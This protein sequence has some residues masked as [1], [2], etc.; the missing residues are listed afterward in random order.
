MPIL[1]NLIGVFTQFN[2]NYSII[3]KTLKKLYL[4]CFKETLG[5]KYHITMNKLLKNKEK[6]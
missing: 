2:I 1:M 5:K 3:I 4:F 6:K